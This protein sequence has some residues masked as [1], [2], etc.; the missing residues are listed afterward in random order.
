MFVKM[1]NSWVNRKCGWTI[2]SGIQQFSKSFLRDLCSLFRLVCHLV[3]PMKDKNWKIGI[4]K[5]AFGIHFDSGYTIHKLTTNLA[6]T[7]W[8]LIILWSSFSY[9]SKTK[10]KISHDKVGGKKPKTSQ[11]KIPMK[12]TL[13]GN[14]TWFTIPHVILDNREVIKGWHGNPP[15]Q[16]IFYQL[17]VNFV[18][19][20]YS[21]VVVQT[22]VRHISLLCS[23]V[24]MG[25][26]YWVVT[27][28]TSL[29]SNVTG[30]SKMSFQLLFL[31]VWRITFLLL[32]KVD[33]I[34][35]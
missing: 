2:Q 35:I 22:D 29:I 11:W 8:I 32:H 31:L 5:T 6:I 20:L 33:L 28:G 1:S 19:Y 24:T 27:F 4:E 15:Q 26:L 7:K 25:G 9:K 16:D 17:V 34:E 14:T 30:I 21:F 12:N 3:P 18:N 10:K 23:G 13:Q